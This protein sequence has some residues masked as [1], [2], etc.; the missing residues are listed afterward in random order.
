MSQIPHVRQRLS[1]RAVARSMM[2]RPRLLIS[3]AATIAIFL[4]LPWTLPGTV[5][6]A[7]A[8]CAGGVVYVTLA[9]RI[10]WD[11]T[12]ATIRIRAA[13]QDDGA[14]AVL[15]LV[16]LATLSSF[17]AI[18][19]LVAQAKSA[20]HAV[21]VGYALLAVAT[22]VVSWCVIQVTFT[23]HYA[24]EHYQ[25]LDLLADAGKAVAGG[26]VFPSDPAPDYWDFFYFA[27][28]IGASAQTSDV[29]IRSKSLRR[30]VTMHAI[31]SFFFN[32]TVLAL[33]V[34]LAASS[35]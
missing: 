15:V 17:A 14:V 23:L 28:S 8:W 35:I 7:V 19:D 6:A 26:L 33:A 21:R 20:S 12:D 22:L 29:A 18:A 3:A 25:P 24:H 4:L 2:L 11:C 10:M 9:F 13:R 16:V 31:V 30:L 32:T 27:T 5:R 34:N 1:F